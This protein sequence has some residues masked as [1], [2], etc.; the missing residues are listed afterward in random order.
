MV[1]WVILTPRKTQPF[2]FCI[3]EIKFQ[4]D[5]I[6]RPKRQIKK[7]LIGLVAC[8]LGVSVEWR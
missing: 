7:A 5:R 8:K 1:K 6:E 2:A 3:D 4:T